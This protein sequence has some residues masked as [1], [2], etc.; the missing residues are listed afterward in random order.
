MMI[1]RTLVFLGLALPVAAALAQTNPGNVPFSITPVSAP[2]DQTG[3]TAWLATYGEGSRFIITLRIGASSQGPFQFSTGAFRRIEGSNSQPL[4]SALAKALE[5]KATPAPR[6]AVQ[7]LPFNVAILGT[8]RTRLSAEGGFTSNPP[9]TWIVTKVFLADGAGEVYL[10]LD[11]ASGTGE[12]SIKDEEYG[13][14]VLRELAS[15][16]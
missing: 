1:R 2:S 6:K 16:L 13:D 15:V 3:H 7:V 10:N 14:I 12:F 5:A 8:K 11:P 4:L 9:G